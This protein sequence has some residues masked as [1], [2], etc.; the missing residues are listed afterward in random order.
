MKFSVTFILSLFLFFPQLKAQPQLVLAPFATGF[1]SP[2]FITN[3]GDER[4]FIVQQRGL[5]R[6]VDPNGSIKSTPFL[7]ITAKVS[8][9]GNERGLLGMAFHPDY[10][11][12]GFFY[13]N[14]TRS[15][16]GATIVA[17]YSV[18]PSNPDVADSAS[19]L[20]LLTVAQSQTNHNGGCILFGN[21]GYLYI[22]MGD[23]G[24]SGDPL[25]DAQNPLSLLGKM[26][27]ID[28]DGVGG[29]D[30]PPD[31]PFFG[32]SSIRNEIWALGLRN[33]WRFSFDRLTHDLWIADVGQ[34][35]REEIH[36]QSSTSVG[37]EN[38]GWR[39]YEGNQPY[40]LNGCQPASAYVFPV[41]EYAHSGSNC[42]GSV[43]GGYVYRGA[44]YNGLFGKYL[45]ADYCKAAFYW[46]EKNDTGFAS[47]TLG[48]FSPFQY[49][50]FGEDVYGEL[51]VTLLGNGSVQK[52]TDT[53]DCRPVALILSEEDTVFF[54][55]GETAS[56][57]ALFHP[58]LN[59]QWKMNGSDITGAG[60]QT[61]LA[62][63]TGDYTVEVTNPAN[64][65]SNLSASVRVELQQGTSINAITNSVYQNPFSIYPN[66][67]KGDFNI[68]CNNS[69]VM[70]EEIALMNSIGETL[71]LKQDINANH[72]FVQTSGLS[73]G[74]YL[75]RLKT[76]D[77]FYFRKV[78]VIE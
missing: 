15:S 9:S 70:L 31:N 37:G 51:Y 71:L 7:N 33:P 68:M 30:I 65:C 75:V 8:A 62:D 64:S 61:L 41:F 66:P 10:A 25:N 59:Y 42:S 28:V 52:I 1:T 35:V 50:S 60:S 3:T 56:L 53:S 47:G 11:A 16:D 2:L 74:I 13:V 14:Y 34:S 67:N 44:L 49:A 72:F 36:F 38:Y 45:A 48:T 29:Y 78:S 18:N 19:E 5:I 73:N 76:K 39:C 58:S 17:R 6:I 4:L 57:N 40:N 46:V 32:M 63:S 21:D 26:L 43:T 20:I 27:R 77:G 55:E 12:N 24:G 22:G 23:G 54:N 69:S